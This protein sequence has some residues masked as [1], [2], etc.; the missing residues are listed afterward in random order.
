M[1]QYKIGVR[2]VKAI[3]TGISHWPMSN[4]ERCILV[5]PQ[6][7]LITVS[8]MSIMTIITIAG[9]RGLPAMA[10]LGWQS[11]ILYLIPAVMFFVPTA[12]ISAELGAT[13]EGGVY[14]WV[15][16]GLGKRFGFI[17]VWMQWIHNVVWYPAQLAFVAAAGA[18]AFGL[19]RLSDSGTYIMIVI[20]VVFW[21]AIWLT[22]RGGNLFAKVA[23]GAGLVGTII[24]ACL[25]LVLGAAWLASGQHISST[26]TES[27][28]IP[29]FTNIAGIA[30]V[31]QNVL[32][33]GGMEVN[34]V[35]AQHMEN[36]KRYTRVVGI[37]FVS[38]LAIFIVPTL[39][40]AM[41]LPKNVNLSDGTVRAFE[42]M[43]STFHLGFMGNIVGLAIVFGAIASIISWISGPSRGLFNAAEDGCLPDYF[44]RT[45]S[46]GAQSG[47]LVLM[48]VI[49]TVLACLYLIFPKSVSMV[50]SLLIGMAVALYVMMYILMFVASIN[51]RRLHKTGNSG[52]RAP[53]LYLMAGMGIV[54]CICAFAMTF[55][56]AAGQTGIPGNWYPVIAGVVVVALAVPS[57]ML[58]RGK[59]GKRQGSDSNTR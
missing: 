45:N 49:V 5:K 31:V 16:E 30:L 40:L 26:L 2:F 9:L 35:H 23:S 44:K 59:V 3:M 4:S 42:I 27:S 8:Q 24:P 13:Y 32:A 19:N 33:F 52:Y 17:A 43:F 15:K 20:V 29:N 54:A 10:I 56:P 6:N 11:I 39:I 48:G 1:S 37:A 53:A 41:V 51:L 47:I 21:W 38:A 46:R 58:Y 34:A 50:F 57:L 12:L 7:T 28:V 36:P 14:E 18:A 55:V 22:L 25:L